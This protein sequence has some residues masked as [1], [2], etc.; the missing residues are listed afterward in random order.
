MEVECNVFGTYLASG[1]LDAAVENPDAPLG[2]K[3]RRAKGERYRWGLWGL[4]DSG[5][6]ETGQGGQGGELKEH[7][8]GGVS[9]PSWANGR[10]RWGGHGLS[11]GGSE[12]KCSETARTVPPQPTA[13]I[14]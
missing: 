8:Q 10:S 5:Q 9:R 13:R 11:P 7:R 12:L 14:G 3:I 6:R 4:R 1:L 2:G